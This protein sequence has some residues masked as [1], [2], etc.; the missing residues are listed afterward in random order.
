MSVF[1][2]FSHGNCSALFISQL[3]PITPCFVF[4]LCFTCALTFSSLS[5][6]SAEKLTD[7]YLKNRGHGSLLKC[8]VSESEDF[9]PLPP[10]VGKELP[11]GQWD[12]ED[13]P[14]DDVKESWE[15]D[16]KPQPVCV[17]PLL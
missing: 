3:P 10:M 16:E 11:K 17:N 1:L 6:A 9:L 14:E 5:F 13:A 4:L 15:D 2:N 12:D 8:F 7:L